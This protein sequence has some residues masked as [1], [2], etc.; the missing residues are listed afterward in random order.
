MRTDHDEQ[1]AYA[2]MNGSKGSFAPSATVGEAILPTLPE[3][4]EQNFT[5]LRH[6]AHNA[7]HLREQ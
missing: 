2:M 4:I 1:V 7:G 3:G 6:V 5:N